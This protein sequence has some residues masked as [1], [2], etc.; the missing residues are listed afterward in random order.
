MRAPSRAAS[1]K[2]FD[3]MIQGFSKV[4]RTEETITPTREEASWL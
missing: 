1:L 2:N 3:Q 4:R